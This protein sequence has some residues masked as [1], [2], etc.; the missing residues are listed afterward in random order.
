MDENGLKT[1][2]FDNQRI[3]KMHLALKK[4]TTVFY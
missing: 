1:L 3:R 4:Y 2:P